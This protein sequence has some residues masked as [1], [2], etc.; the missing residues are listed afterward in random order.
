MAEVRYSPAAR[1]DLHRLWA[2]IAQDLHSP[3]AADRAVV[4]VFE[5][6]EGLERFPLGGASVE[7][8]S[9]RPTDLRYALSGRRVI[10]YR[11]EG[12]VV[13]ILRIFSGGANWLDTLFGA[14][15]SDD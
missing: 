6:V 1:D 4:R 7:A 14:V 3:T 10:V 11:V 12:D 13:Y 9:G 8:L 2:Y 15:F 5:R